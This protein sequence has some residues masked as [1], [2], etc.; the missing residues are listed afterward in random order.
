M[1]KKTIGHNFDV[2]YMILSYLQCKGSYMYKYICLFKHILYTNSKL[3][4]FTIWFIFVWN[5][6]YDVQW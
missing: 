5:N 1:I 2:L 4:P 6:T 3:L